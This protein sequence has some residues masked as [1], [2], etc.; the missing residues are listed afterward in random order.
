MVGHHTIGVNYSEF[1]APRSLPSRTIEDGFPS[2][3]AFDATVGLFGMLEV[4]MGRRESGESEDEKVK[5]LEAGFSVNRVRHENAR[6]WQ[7]H[8]RQECPGLPRSAH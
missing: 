2:D 6:D 1:S 5:K 4:L 3:D 8:R 7:L